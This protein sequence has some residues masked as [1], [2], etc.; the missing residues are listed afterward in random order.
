MTKSALFRLES[1][2]RRQGKYDKIEE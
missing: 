2:L 1:W